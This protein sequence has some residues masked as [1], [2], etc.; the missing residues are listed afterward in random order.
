MSGCGRDSEPEPET[1]PSF[2]RVVSRDS[3]PL[4]YGSGSESGNSMAPSQGPGE[5]RFCVKPRTYASRRPF[6]ASCAQVLIGLGRCRAASFRDASVSWTSS[7]EI[8]ETGK[9]M[10]AGL[11]CRRR[12]WPAAASVA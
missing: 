12:A 6:S 3:S 11:A 2:G 10:D 7:G 1:V 4:S 9:S 8:N 5:L